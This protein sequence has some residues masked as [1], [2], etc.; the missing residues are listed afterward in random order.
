MNTRTRTIDMILTNRAIETISVY[1]IVLSVVID[2]PIFPINTTKPQPIPLIYSGN[3]SNEYT[4]I[5][6][7]VKL[8]SNYIKII[9]IKSTIFELQII[10][11]WS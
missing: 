5:V 8:T 2:K 11:S 4:L 6:A 7:N 3:I 1:V 10:K 9:V